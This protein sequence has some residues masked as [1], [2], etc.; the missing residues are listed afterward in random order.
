M[1]VRLYRRHKVSCPHRADSNLNN[2]RCAIWMQYQIAAGKQIKRSAQTSSVLRAQ[3]QVA[4]LTA[5]KP[6]VREHL[7]VDALKMWVEFREQS[8][9]PIEKARPLSERFENFCDGLGLILLEEIN[10]DHLMKFKAT[11]PYKAVTSSSLKIYWSV[12]TSF[13]T[14]AQAMG[15]ISKS[16]VPNSKVFPAFKIK[17]KKP[18]VKIPSA[19]DVKLIIDSAEGTDKLFLQT[20]RWSGMAITDT[21]TLRR[22]QLVGNIITG[23]RKKTNEK[24]RVR[25]PNWLADAL[26]AHKCSDPEFF[27]WC[28]SKAG[29]KTLPTTIMHQYEARLRLHFKRLKVTITPHKFRHHF[30]SEQLAA[31][32]SAEDVSDMVGTSPA[33]IRKTYKHSLAKGNERKDALQAAVWVTMG[34]DEYGGPTVN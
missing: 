18:E 29:E 2:C 26:R 8:N 3:E 10:T 9:L 16:P 15:L 28:L 5:G 7:L 1:N 27:F 30:I 17:Y 6:D 25:I 22:S 24:F 31:G 11:L 20:L 34:L 21:A 23:S 13:F 14:W 19:A 32:V 33:E 12:F 4:E